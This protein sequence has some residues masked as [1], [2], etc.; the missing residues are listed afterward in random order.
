MAGI[1]IKKLEKELSTA[2][3]KEEHRFL[4][5]EAKKKAITVASN[6]QDFK[7]RVACADLKPLSSKELLSLGDNSRSKPNAVTKKRAKTSLRQ[8][9]KT[10][11]ATI[12]EAKATKAPKSNAEFGRQWRRHCRTLQEKYDYLCLLAE[13]DVRAIFKTEIDATHLSEMLLAM[14]GRFFVGAPPVD[15][16]GERVRTGKLLLDML[17][18]LSQVP[19]FALTYE[20]LEV[21]EKEAAVSLMDKFE[22]LMPSELEQIASLRVSFS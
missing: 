22:V 19:R 3:Q 12:T 17:L 15:G 20:F 4:I 7:N 1:N 14:D 9:N 18:S 10:V 6:Y 2:V 21:K 5:D 16:A 8:K 13:A 11:G